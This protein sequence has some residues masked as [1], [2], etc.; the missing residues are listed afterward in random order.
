MSL[1]GPPAIF[2]SN[3]TP[4]SSCAYQRIQT[5]MRFLVWSSKGFLIRH[6]EYGTAAKMD[7]GKKGGTEKRDT[8]LAFRHRSKFDDALESLGKPWESEH[9]QH[10]AGTVTV[11][12]SFRSLL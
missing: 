9:Q 7:R 4:I 3:S 11:T 2:S 6:L 5:Q 8:H 1:D 10:A 12:V